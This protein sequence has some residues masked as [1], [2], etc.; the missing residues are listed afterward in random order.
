[1]RKAATKGGDDLEVTVLV[2]TFS[3]IHLVLATIR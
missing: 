1:M 2:A 3:S